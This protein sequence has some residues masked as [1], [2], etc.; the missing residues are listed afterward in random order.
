MKARMITLPEAIEEIVRSCDVC[1]V[2]MV[3]ENNMPYTLPFNFGFENN[4]VYLHSAPVGK[5]IS[6]LRNNPYVCIAFSTA[7]Q[8][9][10]QSPEVACSYGMRYKSVLVFGK[11]EFIEDPAEKIGILNII[12]RQYTQRGDFSYSDPSVKNVAVMKVVTDRIEA[13]AFG[14]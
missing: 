10:K 11:V 12:M 13:K 6:V 4:T 5:K 8:L 9:Y 7:H 1:S 3:D 2:G 14:Y